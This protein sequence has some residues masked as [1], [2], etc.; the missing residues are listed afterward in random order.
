M[1]LENENT[2][3]WEGVEA[4]RRRASTPYAQTLPAGKG[5]G[6]PGF[7]CVLSDRGARSV[8]GAPRGPWRA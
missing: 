7:P 4:R 8:A 6:E 1:V 3:S 5:V 2:Y